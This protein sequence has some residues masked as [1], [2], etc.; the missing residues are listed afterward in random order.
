MVGDAWVHDI[1]G[2]VRRGHARG[3]AQPQRPPHPDPAVAPAIAALHPAET[4]RRCWRPTALRNRPAVMLLTPQLAA[5]FA[6]TALANVTREY[7]GKPD[8]VLGRRG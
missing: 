2:A 8:H 3:V 5:S 1:V 7:P 6:R 4:W